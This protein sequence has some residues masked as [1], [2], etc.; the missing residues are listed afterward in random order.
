M[1]I[2]LEI[3]GRAADR[4]WHWGVSQ[5]DLKVTIGTVVYC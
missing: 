3:F 1:I 4:N 5:R 2:M